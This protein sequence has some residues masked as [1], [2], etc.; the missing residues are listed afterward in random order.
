MHFSPR[1]RITFALVA[2]LFASV[3]L[4]AAE[5][6]LTNWVVPTYHR[7]AS[8]SGGLST[9]A[10]ITTGSAFVGMQPCRLVDTR[11]SQGFA[12]QWGPPILAANAIRT[13]DLNSAP[14]CTGIPASVEA[15]SLNFAVTETAGQPGDIRAWPTGTPP[16]TVTSVLNWNFVGAAAIANSIII[17]AGTGGSIDVQ[18]AG[19]NTHLVIDING[20]FTTAYNDGNAFLATGNVGAFFFPG[21]LVAGLNANTG[22]FAFGVWG[23]S[24]SAGSDSAGVGGFGGAT[25]GRVYGVYGS[26]ESLADHSAGVFGTTDDMAYGACADCNHAGVYGRGLTGP[27]VLGVSN[28]PGESGGVLGIYTTSAGVENTNSRGVLGY[29]TTA[30][31]RAVNDISKGGVVSF[32]EPH[33]TDASKKLVYVALEGNEAGTYFRGR[34]RFLNGQA[35]IE[36][37]E[38][39]RMVTSP[40]GLSVQ[41]T[42]I[43]QMATVA[44][45]DLS[46]DRIVVRG[47][48]NVEFFYT[49]NGVRRGYGS[50]R[51]IAD[52]DKDYIPS[53][54]EAVLPADMRPELRERLIR[55]G[56]YNP[57]GT[58]NMET[59][60][61]LGW[62]QTWAERPTGLTPE[63]LVRR[64]V[65]EQG[66]T[67]AP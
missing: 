40:E 57:D 23:S 27:G 13:F 48:R 39:F 25:T 15:Y 53:S 56:T 58:V 49:V 6:P 42:P 22:S 17:P 62:E 46:L 54:P 7:P 35:V 50:F 47:S 9:M 11:P 4:F 20:Y 43:G 37:P 65:E 64:A 3:P 44:I 19:F 26:S 28:A 16:T 67:R 29:S 52:N 63:Q 36:V 18:V 45:E 51:P 41:V 2:L 30:G 5:I 12:G 34:G 14:H 21:F 10:D 1:Q 59:A 8:A 31:V 24:S 60:R 55:N 38:D 61:R 66:G 32:T 33:A